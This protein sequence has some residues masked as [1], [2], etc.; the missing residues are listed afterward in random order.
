VFHKYYNELGPAKLK[1]LIYLEKNILNEY[2]I[3]SNSNV[4]DNMISSKFSV[5]SRYTNK[6][7]KSELQCIYDSLGIVKTAKASDMNEYYET[8]IVSI[9]INGKRDK[10]LELISKK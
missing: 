3:G 5:S 9:V 1:T 7:L 2:K 10:G 6:Y 4:I 8:K